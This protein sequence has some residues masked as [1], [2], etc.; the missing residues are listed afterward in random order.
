[1]YSH[2]YPI[3]I[4]LIE[5]GREKNNIID[6]RNNFLANLS[7]SKICYRDSPN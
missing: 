7:S 5:N 6:Y 4:I 3:V 2:F 1:M